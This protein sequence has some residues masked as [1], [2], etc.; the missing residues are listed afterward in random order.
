M[1]RVEDTH[2]IGD[3]GREDDHAVGSR[4][5]TSELEIAERLAP[6]L[7]GKVQNYLRILIRCLRIGASSEERLHDL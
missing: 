3:I 2:T 1:A 4:N 7:A 6:R 5:R